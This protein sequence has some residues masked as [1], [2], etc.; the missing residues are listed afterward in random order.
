MDEGKLPSQK[1]WLEPFPPGYLNVKLFNPFI[2]SMKSA[3][4]RTDSPRK[5]VKLVPKWDGSISPKIFEILKLIVTFEL[6]VGSFCNKLF[7]GKLSTLG[8]Q[9]S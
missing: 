4:F 9:S 3:W 1:N 7:S 2:L 6:L 8:S 5:W